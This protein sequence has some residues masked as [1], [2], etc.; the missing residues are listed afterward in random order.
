M[1][2]EIAELII[3]QRRIAIVI[4]IVLVAFVR[5]VPLSSILLFSFFERVSGSEWR[6]L[7]KSMLRKRGS[8]F[9]KKAGRLRWGQTE[10]S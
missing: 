1:L 10:Y 5:I 8:H 3:N 7:D 2:A 9:R 4:Y 6:N